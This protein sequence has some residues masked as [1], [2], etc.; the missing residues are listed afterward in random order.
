MKFSS[1][2]IPLPNFRWD[3]NLIQDHFHFLIWRQSKKFSLVSTIEHTKRFQS[4]KAKERGGIIKNV[5]VYP[6]S[7]SLVEC[8]SKFSRKKIIS[9]SL[10][11]YCLPKFFHRHSKAW[12]TK[13]ITC[14]RNQQK[15]HASNWQRNLFLN[16]F[17]IRAFSFDE[18]RFCGKPSRQFY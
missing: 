13:L 8:F 10:L 6:K 18:T 15:I 17:R 2:C 1:L 16:S 14:F 4:C 7:A 9:F 5:L 12:N 3:W 11:L